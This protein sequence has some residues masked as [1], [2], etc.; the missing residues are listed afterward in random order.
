MTL[1]VGET[2][3]VA[4]QR[5]EGR[6]SKDTAPLTFNV[7]P[8]APFIE[9]PATDEPIGRRVVVSGFGVP[10]DTVTVKLGDATHAVL[11]SSPVAGGSHLVGDGGVRSTRRPLRPDGRGVERGF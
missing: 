10:G 2:T 4:R 1:P 6:P 9:T 11:G 8:A 7:V 5:F 3:I